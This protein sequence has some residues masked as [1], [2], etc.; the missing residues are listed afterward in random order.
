MRYRD[1]FRLLYGGKLFKREG[2]KSVKE[3]QVTQLLAAKIL[4][5]MLGLSEGDQK[6]LE[7]VALVHDWTKRL[8]KRPEDFSSDDIKK[9]ELFLEKAGPD[10]DLMAA[11]GPEFL[12]KTLYCAPSF[13]EFLQFYLDDITKGSEI[14][15]FDDRIDEVSARRQDLNEDQ[16][17]TQRLAGRRYWDLEREIGHEVEKVIFSLLT[18]KGIS[19]TS[20]KEIPSLI[21]S[22]MKE[23]MNG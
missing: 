16:I 7:K 14:V 11:T 15:C 12:E 6:K 5:G 1:E 22:K 4:G 23:Q 3:H 13:L 21:S 8:D 18:K 19:L 20:P 2:W 17:L 10:E 9:I